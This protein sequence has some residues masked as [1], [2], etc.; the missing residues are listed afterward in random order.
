M[1]SLNRTTGLSG[2]G[3]SLKKDGVT[4]AFLKKKKKKER[5]EKKRKPQAF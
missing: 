2:Q 3:C 5:K 4:E 1:T